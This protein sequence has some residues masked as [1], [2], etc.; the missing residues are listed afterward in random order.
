[1]RQLSRLVAVIVT[2][3]ITLTVQA[4]EGHGFGSGLIH[5]AEHL[6]WLLAIFTVSVFVWYKKSYLSK[7]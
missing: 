4:H 7:K 6:L 5:Q 1:M 3:A 2:M